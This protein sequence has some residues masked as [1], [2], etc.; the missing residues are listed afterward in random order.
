VSL[1]KLSLHVIDN[2]SEW[3]GKI[4]CYLVVVVAFVI[5]YEVVSR[6]VFNVP[7]IWSQKFCSFSFGSYAVLGGAY[8]LHRGLHVKVDIFYARFSP[9]L[10]AIIDLITFV[11]FLAFVVSMFWFGS[12][13]AWNSLKIGELETSTIWK[14]PVYPFKII[15]A[16][17]PL[18]LLLQGVAKFTRDLI[19]AITGRLAP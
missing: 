2:I 9:R 3:T 12:M 4:V 10:K 18:L 13:L 17:G 19:T 11:L 16:L 1:T 6:I 7:T 15:M 14:V 8:A 5:M